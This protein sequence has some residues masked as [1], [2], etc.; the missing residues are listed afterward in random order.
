MQDIHGQGKAWLPDD[1]NIALVRGLIW[2][3]ANLENPELNSVVEHIGLLSFKKVP[4]FGPLS[5]KIGNSCVYMF[6]R[7]PV[8]QGVPVL[9]KY[10]SKIK[11]ASTLKYINNALQKLADSKGISTAEVE[12]QGVPGFGFDEQ[13]EIKQPFGEYEAVIRLEGLSDVNLYWRKDEKDRKSIPADIKIDFKSEISELRKQIKEIKTTLSAQRWRLESCYLDDREWEY[14]YW[15]KLYETHPFISY[16]VSR[17]IWHFE[18]DNRST[19][20]FMHNDKW[21]DSNGQ[22]IN[23]ITSS[24]RVRLWHPSMDTVEN[25]RAWRNFIEDNQY[26]QPFKQAH[27]EIYILTDA[28]VTTETYSNRFAAHIL[29]QH[30]FAALCQQRF[31]KY[32]LQ[33]QWDSHNTPTRQIPAFNMYAEY[34]VDAPWEGEAG[35]SGI[36]N[37]VHTDQVRFYDNREGL[38]PLLQ[39]PRIVFSEIMRDVD[40]FVGVTS[41]GNDPSWADGRN[42]QMD[43]YWTDY[44]T[45]ALTEN[46]RVRKE[47]LEKIISRLKIAKV[48]K[49][50]DRFLRIAGK[51]RIYK[52]HMGSGNILMEP[53]NSYLCIVP[54]QSKNKLS[55]VYLPFEGDRMLSIILSKAILLADDDKIT[56]QTILSQINRR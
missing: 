38:L 50:D 24:T 34:W 56:D 14:D 25:I 55:K 2:N 48:A 21:C 30:Q 32:H 6:T 5:V 13:Y 52:I 39:V 3:G 47:L 1:E 51:K 16:P 36:F 9:S 54:D 18:E 8:I 41:I 35:P 23:W 37:Y 4:G 12:E 10:K 11:Y 22:P 28:E 15:A 45:A 42:E 43:N 49:F 20:G 44:S 29:R 46:A 17:L 31:W 26:R 53:D 33:G 7:V 27:R 40:L 19:S